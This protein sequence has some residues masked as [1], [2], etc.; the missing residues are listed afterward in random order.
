MTLII[1]IMI[2]IMI[3]IIIIIIIVKIIVK[4]I[5]II[6]SIINIIRFINNSNTATKRSVPR[7]TFDTINTYFYYKYF[8][9]KF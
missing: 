3:M 4:I 8:R 2:M 1:I 7:A 9:S 6:I 5:I